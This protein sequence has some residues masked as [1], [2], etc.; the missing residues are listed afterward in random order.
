MAGV[1]VRCRE[2]TNLNLFLG[3]LFTTPMSKPV[4]RYAALC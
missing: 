1:R 4:G 2:K 3:W